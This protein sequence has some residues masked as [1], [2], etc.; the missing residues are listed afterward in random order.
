MA[1]R[2]IK[3]FCNQKH[4]QVIHKDINMAHTLILASASRS[5]K[6][7]LSNAG[8]LFEARPCDL[9]ERSISDDLVRTGAPP[10]KVAYVLASEKAKAVSMENPGK[11][12]IGADQLLVFQGRIFSKPANR[13]NAVRQLATLAGNE[14]RLISAV[15]VAVDGVV[16]WHHVTTSKMLM[17]KFSDAWLQN[18]VEK[19]WRKIRH[20]VGAY[21]IE[22]EGAR[23]FKEVQGDIFSIQGL[24]LL[25][26]L[27]YLCDIGEL[28]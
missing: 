17:R 2:I 5:R 4:T 14:H 10:K 26:L 20:C 7:L 1:D 21:R 27:G 8:L 19:N 15:V 28:P 3:Q 6:K 24:P 23:L 22:K 12:V 11:Q 9:D 18:Y 16:A 25:P 13:K